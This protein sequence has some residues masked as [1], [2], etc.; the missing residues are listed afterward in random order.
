[1]KPSAIG[2]PPR[3][4]IGTASWTDPT[5]VKSDTFYP[6]SLRTAEERLRFYASQFNTVEVDASYYTLLSEKN[7]QLWA[8]RTPPGFIFD[9]KAFALLTQHAA[10]VARLPLNVKA[11][12]T[13][14][15]RA[16]RRLERP[17]KEVLETAF[18]MF[19][20]SLTPLRAAGKLGMLVFQFPPYF[21]CRS[22]NFAYLES[23]RARLPGD[24]IAIEFRH[25]S[26]VAEGRQRR[27]S[28][29]F[30]RSNGLCYVSVDE[31]Q[32]SST[33]PSFLETT[34][35]EAYIRF[36]GRNREAWHARGI[37]VA[38][39][40]KYLYSERELAEWAERIR[41]LGGISRAHVIFNNCYRNFGVMNATTMRA[42]LERSV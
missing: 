6:S 1:M 21:T 39:R 13:R 16:E 15:E 34:T 31:P 26:W 7:S 33:L 4:L 27:E 40:Y 2:S 22:S 10:E 23:L 36:H 11:M 24:S 3:Y 37:T 30:L 5:L 19:H 12:L 41:G 9:V 25:S 38:E 17:S 20:S 32:L 42:M 14:Q 18:Q 29:D 35:A 28:L 8:E